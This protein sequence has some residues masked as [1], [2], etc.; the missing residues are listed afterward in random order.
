MEYVSRHSDNTV[1][2]VPQVYRFF[3]H[4]ELVDMQFGYLVMEFVSGSTLESC[5]VESEMIKRI[6]NVIDHLSTLP[7][8][9]S[10]GPGPAYGGIAQ[11]CLWTEY[12]AGT[13][14]K[15]VKDMENWLNQRLGLSKR[16]LPRFSL[17]LT[18]LYFSHMDIARRNIILTETDEIY[19]IDWAYAGFYPGYFQRLCIEW[20]LVDDDSYI[21][22]LLHHLP[23]SYSNGEDHLLGEV[24]RVNSRYLPPV[25]KSSD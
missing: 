21:L 7:M 23:G 20:C 18:E 11:G 2:R 6:V 24:L 4:G 12:G 8:P 9:P 22:S 1:M 17:N 14:F 10:Q 3:T 19:L 5:D 13:P 16:H 15:S 25:C